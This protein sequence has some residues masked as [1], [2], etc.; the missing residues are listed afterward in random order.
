M[1]YVYPAIFTPVKEGGYSVSVPDV[2]GCHTCGDTLAEAIEMAEDALAMCLDHAESINLA[3][4]AA[5]VAIPHK[6]PQFVNMI[7]ADT[8]AYRKLNSKR[9][10]NK[11]LT[12]PAW[13]NYR[14]E[15]ANIN[16]SKAL[17]KALKEELQL[18]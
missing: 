18:V 3:I 13:L 9:S 17:Q 11:T 12:L 6:F 16:F 4:P 7:L 1:K 10:V 14:A 5:S 15:A 8:D 2:K